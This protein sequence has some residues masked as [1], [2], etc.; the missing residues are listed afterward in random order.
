MEKV[1]DTQPSANATTKVA[2]LTDVAERRIALGPETPVTSTSS[3][4][5]GVSSV[6]AGVTDVVTMIASALRRMRPATSHDFNRRL[7]RILFQPHWRPSSATLALTRPSR[8]ERSQVSASILSNGWGGAAS[9]M[10]RCC[11]H[12]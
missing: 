9:V 12:I 3:V 10:M 4:T 2:R 1:A 11:L 7:V 6:T 8:W 5:A